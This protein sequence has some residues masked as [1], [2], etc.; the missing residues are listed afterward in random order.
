MS[1]YQCFAA[2]K[3]D[4]VRE[5]LEASA[6]NAT[7]TAELGSEDPAKTG[8]KAGQQQAGKGRSDTA[9]P[10]AAAEINTDK[11][12]TTTTQDE[13]APIATSP[14]KKKATTAVAVSAA[15]VEGTLKK[16]WEDFDEDAKEEFEDLAKADKERVCVR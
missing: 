3:R 14:T 7:A 5:E 8:D 16:Q 1:A 15:Q 12:D 2:T 10:T 6:N 11:I 13:A 9:T 4:A